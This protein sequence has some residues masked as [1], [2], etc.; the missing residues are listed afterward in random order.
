MIL[1]EIENN[2]DSQSFLDE[3]INQFNGDCK[4]VMVLLYKGIR[5]NAKMLVQEYGLHDRRLRNC[6]AARPDV[7]KKAWKFD[8]NGKRLFVEYFIEQPMPETKKQLVEWAGNYLEKQ[9]Q[10]KQQSLF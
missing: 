10:L 3:N 8:E 4:K 2:P 6:I 5:L 1:H 9:A 7:V